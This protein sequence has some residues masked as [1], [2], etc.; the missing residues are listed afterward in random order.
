MLRDLKV[1]LWDLQ[2]ALAEIETFIAGKTCDDY[3]AERMLQRA[4]ERDFIVIGEVLARILHHFPESKARIDHAREIA[5]FRNILVH[6]YDRIQ[7]D[8]VWKIITTSVP[9]LKIQV[10]G[11]LFELDTKPQP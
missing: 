2:K 11:W 6:E 9:S 8:V 3:R 4:V 7:D 1:Y 5:E 10:D